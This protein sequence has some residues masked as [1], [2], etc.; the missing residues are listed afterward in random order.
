MPGGLEKWSA[1]GLLVAACCVLALGPADATACTDADQDG[2]GVY[3]E[4]SRLAGCA[5]DGIDCDDSD[6]AV[7][8]FAEEICGNGVDDNCRHGADEG[9]GPEPDF[10]GWRVMP[11]RSQ[12]QFERG[13]PGG[14]AEQWLQGAARCRADPNVAYLSHDC[15]QVW[16]SRDGGRSWEKPLDLGLHLPMGQSIEVDPVDCR[17]V[18]IILDNAYD[19]RH[20]EWPGIY[21]STDGGDH[22]TFV[23]AGPTLNNRRYEHN[24]AWA[25]S[26]V[27]AQGARRWVAA[28]YNEASEPGHDQSGLYLS[29]DRGQTWSRGA[30]LAAH[31]IVYEVQVSPSDADRVL[32]ASSEGL[33]A[34]DDGG[35]HI[36]PLGDLPAG[37]VSSVAFDPGDAAQILAVSRADGAVGLYR[38]G[39]GGVHFTRLTVGDSAQQAV[40]DDA[41]RL[42]VYPTDGDVFWVLPQT[43]SSSRTA[44]RTL[45]RGASFA[46]TSLSL[47]DDVRQWRWGLYI[48]GDFA[49]M[50]PSAADPADVVAQSGGAALYRSEDGLVFVNGS[51][52]YTGA[53][54]GLSNHN[55]AFAP[56][57]PDIFALGNADIGMYVTF[58]RSDWFVDRGVPW[59]W[60]H[61]LVEWSS[62]YTIDFRPGFPGEMVGVA[63][64]VFD[65]KLVHT[66][67]YGQSWEIADDRSGRYWRVAYHPHAPEVV[68]AGD[69]RSIDGG[70]SYSRMPFPAGLDDADIQVMD[71]C[72]AQP[73]VIYTASRDSGR[74]L[75]SDDRGDSWALYAEPSGSMAPFDSRP[76]FAV[77]PMD[78]NRIY[79]LDARGDLARFDGTSWESLGVLD[80]HQVPGGYY[81]FVRSVMVDPNHP[82]IIY[83]GMLGSGVASVYRSVDDGQ[84]WTDISQN[85]FREGVGGINVSPHSGEVLVSGCSGTWVLP[86]PYPT[87]LG[88]YDRLYPRP[89]CFDG[90]QNGDEQGVD[91]GGICAQPCSPTDGGSE[92]GGADAGDGGGP[93]SGGD[94]GGSDTGAEDAGTGDP[95]PAADGGDAAP[96]GPV[97]SCGCG[98]QAPASVWLTLLGL[99]A[100]GL[101][102]R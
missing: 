70:R 79:T 82:E 45:D 3:P 56:E 92:D 87:H 11:V 12:G 95:G 62:Q 52:L 30:S 53:N 93:D 20:T 2:Y 58:N 21:R 8:P 44:I 65:K 77:D 37:P 10:D 33:F 75:R 67:D 73:D 19:Y 34:S 16:R 15:G 35:A 99:V 102:R 4:T 17:T 43:G 9:C 18:I 28:L 50:L 54:C 89:S 60:V 76:T 42:F 1:G 59:E 25:L 64:Y 84:T 61:N 26:S 55:I 68:Y 22:W 51:T 66:S 47:P 57:D 94:T 48:S 96:Q 97:G 88:L 6:P 83:A 29:A 80:A 98:A 14:R 74:V 69:L 72:R 24:L 85:R 101:R 91:C 41:R 71:Y 46:A 32:V 7:H 23:Q 27:D 49:F 90:L 5:H 100:L 86:P 63:G 13:E 40:L 38:S 36:A 31:E 39:D 78:C 81:D